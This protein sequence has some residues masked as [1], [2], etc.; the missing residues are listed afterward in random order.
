VSAL[1]TYPASPLLPGPLVAQGKGIE[2][3]LQL[4]FPPSYFRFKVLPPRITR[5]SWKNLT[6]GNQPFLGLGWNG[7]LPD[8]ALNPQFIGGSSW[9]LLTSVRRQGTDAERYYGDA[10]GIGVMTMAG[11][12]VSLLQGA[13]IEGGTMQVTKV[14]NVVA[15][16][17]GDDCAIIAL[18]LALSIT[19]PLAQVIAAPPGLGLFEEMASAWGWSAQD[20]TEANYTSDWTNPNDQT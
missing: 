13:V 2:R 15:D 17:W 12:A 7:L 20:G 9:T 6:T 18:D 1:Y 8:R 16:G 10:Q 11:A 19:L 3:L 5:E 4:V 14:T